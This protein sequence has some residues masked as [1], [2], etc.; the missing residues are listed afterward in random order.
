MLMVDYKKGKIFLLLSYGIQLGLKIKLEAN[1][2]EKIIH[3]YRR[4][5]GYGNLNNEMKIQ[6]SAE[7]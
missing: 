2:Q 5:A 4:F 6:R 3:M 7:I 1:K